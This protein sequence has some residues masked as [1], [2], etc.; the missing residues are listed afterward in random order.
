MAARVRT[1]VLISG[2]G[3]NLAALIAATR[4]PDYPAEIVLVISNMETAAGLDVARRSSVRS[5]V[6]P[7]NEFAGREEFDD[8]VDAA[9]REAG[10]ALV[11]EPG[12][13]RIHS[14]GFVR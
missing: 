6:I 8:R 12:F 14:D 5:A 7:H 10:V 1:A 11:C 3:S 9:L 4:A 13:M 2:R